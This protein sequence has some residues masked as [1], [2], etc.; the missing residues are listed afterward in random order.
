MGHTPFCTVFQFQRAILFVSDKIPL[1]IHAILCSLCLHKVF[2][3]FYK[4]WKG[5]LT[6]LG[7]P[8]LQNDWIIWSPLLHSNFNNLTTQI[9]C[10]SSHTMH[11]HESGVLSSVVFFVAQIK[12]GGPNFLGKTN[13]AER[14]NYLAPLLYFNFKN[15]NNPNSLPLIPYQCILHE[16]A[17]L[18]SVF[19]N[20]LK[21]KRGSNFLEGTNSAERVNYLVSS[22][23]FQF[24]KFQLPKLFIIHL[25]SMRSTWFSSTFISFLKFSR[26]FMGVSLMKKLQGPAAGL[27]DL[28]VKANCLL[29]VVVCFGAVE[30]YWM[31][32]GLFKRDDE[33]WYI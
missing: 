21:L 2:L 9:L 30:L 7:E 24:Q 28:V 27:W 14:L 10:H 22:S 8:I 17:V 12:E 19:W 32:F 16:S 29:V 6:T 1:Y 31:L 25:I 13:S 4:L 15:L 23:V 11:L 5:E 26:F 20:L 33:G 18:F 3:N